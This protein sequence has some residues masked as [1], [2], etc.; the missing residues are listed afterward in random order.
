MIDPLTDFLNIKITRPK[1]EK[2][3]IAPDLPDCTD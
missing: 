3:P 1:G 2:D